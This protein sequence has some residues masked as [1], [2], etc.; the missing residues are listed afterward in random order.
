MRYLR[1]FCI[2]HGETTAAAANGSVFNGWTDVDLSDK[3]RR[4]LNEAADALQGIKFDAIWSSDLKRAAYGALA[5]AD[6][7]GIAPVFTEEFRELNFGD[8]EG[9]PFDE[10][11]DR[12]PDLAD[13]LVAPKGSDFRFPNGESSGVFRK[14][15]KKALENL[16]SRHPTGRV[17]LFSHAGVGR[18]LLADV[19]ELGF[20]QMW[21]LQQ[22]HASLNVIDIFPNG[23]LRVILVNGYLGPSGYFGSGPGYDR[24]AG[25]P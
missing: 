14:R 2:R 9:L 4:Q 16:T 20:H 8:C 18:A 7:T 10:I 11:N 12:Y 15:I 22:D 6:R 25:K 5:L 19:L 3:G 13:A 23:G 24:L 1:L 21:A 17:A